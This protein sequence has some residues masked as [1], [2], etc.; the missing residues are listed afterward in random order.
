MVL[1]FKI[2]KS[3]PKEEYYPYSIILQG[4]DWNDY[5]DAMNIWLKE[6][7]IP[8]SCVGNQFWFRDE[9]HLTMFALRWQGV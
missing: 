8:Y 1:K 9:E 5:T 7:S 6:L 3:D 4:I 2:I